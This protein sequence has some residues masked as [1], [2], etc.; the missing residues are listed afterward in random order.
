MS[1][2]QRQTRHPAG[3]GSES[4]VEEPRILRM[5]SV[6]PA[7]PD[8]HDP[9]PMRLIDKAAI[10]PD[11]LEQEPAQVPGGISANVFDR[12][13]RSTRRLVARAD[14]AVLQEI[15]RSGSIRR[16]PEA[17]G[18]EVRWLARVG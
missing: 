14:G 13:L 1:S 11:F 10:L 8:R 12:V 9:G 15:W 2:M 7:V 18:V 17:A 5:P 6:V 3:P 4:P 16:P